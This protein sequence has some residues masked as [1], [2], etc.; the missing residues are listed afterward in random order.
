MTL[1]LKYCHRAAPLLDWSPEVLTCLVHSDTCLG[2]WVCFD[3]NKCHIAEEARAQK[4]PK[5]C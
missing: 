5:P 1:T 4:E 3:E 2:P